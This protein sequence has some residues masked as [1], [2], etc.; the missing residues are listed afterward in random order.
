MSNVQ[1]FVIEKGVLKK[2][3]G[4]GEDVAIPEG[5]TSIGPSAF[6]QCIGLTSITIPGSVTGIA[7]GAFLNCSSL[8]SVM[9][10]DGVTSIANYAFYNCSSMRNITIPDS[11]T[12]IGSKV[13]EKCSALEDVTW[14]SALAKELQSCMPKGNNLR[15]LHIADISGVSAKF[16]P[17]AAVGFAEDR[18]DC[19]DE[20]GKK[21]LKYIKSNATKLAALAT[22]HPALLYLM[23][24]EKLI[25]AK[26]LEAVTN[27]VQK[28]SNAELIAAILNYGNSSVSQ[29]DKVKVQQKK[30]EREANVTNFIFDAEKLEALTGKNFVVTGKLK[31]FV[32]HDEL[33]ACLTTSGATLAENLAEG[34][35]YLITNTPDS[36]TAKNQ[37]A[38]E[39]GI[40]RITEEHFNEMIGRKAQ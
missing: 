5:V 18:R 31:T 32:S 8:A 13:F 37:K 26:D 1:D 15:I 17:L 3:T 14:P 23:I 21:Y 11:V 20:N 33:K 22:E 24:R 28:T 16:R 38:V 36:G 30:E 25:A 7:F 9:I 27:I 40:R 12:S 4:T 35:D 34:V 29:E 10:P 6:R 2:H 39:L 19:T